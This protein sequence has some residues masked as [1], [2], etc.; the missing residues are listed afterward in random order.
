MVNLTINIPT[1]SDADSSFPKPVNESYTYWSAIVKHFLVDSNTIEIHCWNEEKE[2]I[3]EIISLGKLEMVKEENETIFRGPKSRLLTEYLLNNCISKNGGLKWF[4][5][6][7]E[8]MGLP[9]FHSGH[10]GT[11]LVL[12]NITTEDI[13]FIKRVTPK[14]TVFLEY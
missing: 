3:N 14:A 2:I 9:L 7:L 12:T 4:T 1:Y 10:W 8:Q 6:N 5:L 13:A 11:E